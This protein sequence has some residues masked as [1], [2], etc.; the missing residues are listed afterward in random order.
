MPEDIVPYLQMGMMRPGLPELLSH[1][2]HIGATVV[3]YTHSEDKWAVKVCQA[4][5]RV[6]GWPF[7]FRVYSQMGASLSCV[8]LLCTLRRARP[9]IFALHCLLMH[10]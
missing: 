1:L 8:L 4:L 9:D 5:E 7:I 6:A 2:R 10:R 3:V